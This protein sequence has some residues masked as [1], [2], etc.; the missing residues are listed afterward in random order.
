MASLH[1]ESGEIDLALK[2]LDQTIALKR[3]IGQDDWTAQSIVQAADLA[4]QKG[5]LASAR[6]L[7]EQARQI[8]AAAHKLTSVVNATNFLAVIARDEEKLDEAAK[9]AE[10]A[11]I[12]ARKSGNLGA[13]S[14]S[15]RTFASVRVKQNKLTEART[16]IDEVEA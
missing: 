13:V 8:F 7:I 4:Y 10:E 11:L 1:A 16:L 5:D 12:L 14:G 6:R 15:A 3:E 2:E 9:Y